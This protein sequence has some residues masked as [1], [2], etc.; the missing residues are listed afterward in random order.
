MQTRIRQFISETAVQYINSCHVHTLTITI[1]S[2]RVS[3]THTPK[4]TIFN[5]YCL[6]RNA[7]RYTE[8]REQ[9]QLAQS[10]STKK[11][12]KLINWKAMFHSR[13]SAQLSCKLWRRVNC[14]IVLS[15]DHMHF[16][17]NLRATRSKQV[18]VF[19][20]ARPLYITSKSHCMHSQL[21]C[22]Q[23]VRSTDKCISFIRYSSIIIIFVHYSG[24]KQS[25]NRLRLT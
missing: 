9:Y 10:M 23:C 6:K 3:H 4:T 22:M 8:N 20:H 11:I 18:L 17:T 2:F 1:A 14:K 21:W 16:L 15:P 5:Q 25:N 13:I 19:L 12:F 7:M 24:M